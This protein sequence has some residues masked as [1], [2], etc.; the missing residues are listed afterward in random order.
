[1]AGHI[2]SFI[3]RSG[4]KQT[5]VAERKRKQMAIEKIQNKDTDVNLISFFF[6]LLWFSFRQLCVINLAN[7]IH[8][9][10]LTIYVLFP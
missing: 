5:A 9:C 10:L 6:S 2:T 1:M 8:L 7:D 3:P 4:K